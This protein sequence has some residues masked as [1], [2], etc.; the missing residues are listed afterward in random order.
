[1]TSLISPIRYTT[2]D[3]VA[4]VVARCGTQ[5]TRLIAAA[6]LEAARGDVEA[7]CQSWAGDHTHWAHRVAYQRIT[8]LEASE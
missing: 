5:C 2:P 7:A 3:K 1:M 8:S 4:M 6:H